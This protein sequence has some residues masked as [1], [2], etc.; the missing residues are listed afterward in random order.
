V[1]KNKTL[2]GECQYRPIE[3]RTSVT[4]QP[5]KHGFCQECFERR[6]ARHAGAGHR[7]NTGR[8]QEHREDRYETK[9]GRD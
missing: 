8:T 5:V 1:A 2:C 4:G 9:Y 7:D 3:Y 6:A